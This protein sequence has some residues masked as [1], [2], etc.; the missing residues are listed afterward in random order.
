MLTTML[1]FSV[2][3]LCLVVTGAVTHLL[4]GQPFSRLSRITVT[5]FGLAI[6]DALMLSIFAIAYCVKT[7]P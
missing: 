2:I 4:E 1:V 7:L 6:A 5:L 3:L